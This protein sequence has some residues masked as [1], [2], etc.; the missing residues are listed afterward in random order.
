MNVIIFIEDVG[1]GG[2]LRQVSLLA[3][4]LRRKGH[5]VSLLGLAERDLEWHQVWDS[6]LEL[7]VLYRKKAR[8]GIIRAARFIETVALL[9]RI[10]RRRKIDVVYAVQGD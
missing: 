3:E 4:G 2:V 9:R 7:A 10:L 6:T 5:K 1:L 8:L